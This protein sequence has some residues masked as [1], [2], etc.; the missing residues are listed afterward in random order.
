MTFRKLTVGVL[1]G[2][3]LLVTGALAQEMGDNPLE[4][5]RDI[6]EAAAAFQKYTA[7][8]AAIGQFSG[9][10]SVLK[11]VRAG[12][13]YEPAQLEQ[14]MIAY[15][16]IA[17]L[18]DG[19]FIQGVERAARDPATRQMLRDRLVDNPYDV[20]Q[21]EGMTAAARRVEDAL[22]AQATPLSAAGAEVKAAAY[23][24]QHQS[25]SQ[26]MVSDAQGRLAEVKRLSAVRARPGDDDVSSMVTALAA[27][28]P[29]TGVDGA[30]TGLSAVQAKALALAAEAILDGAHA[31]DRTRLAPL[32][33]EPR[34]AMC[35]RMAKLNLYQ[36]MAVA[37]PQYE[38][39]FCLGQHALIDTGGCVAEAVRPPANATIAAASRPANPLYVPLAAHRSLRVD[40]DQ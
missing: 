7:S 14:G 5:P 26:A 31:S 23:T 30:P 8:A 33:S 28:A 4:L 19:D 27:A 35:I 20:V 13:A 32:L 25:W 34:S 6:V 15:G 37:G 11:G 18:Q 2:A 21:F 29:K 22:T 40:P 24:V 17:A 12:V 39:I 36:C 16:A 38:D 9:A 10:D 1:A 3:S